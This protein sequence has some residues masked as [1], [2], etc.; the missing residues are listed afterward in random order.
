MQRIFMVSSVFL[1]AV[2]LTACASAV[3]PTRI[4]DYVSAEH[5]ADEAALLNLE[6]RPLQAGLVLVSDTTD[7]G[8]APN[9]P[10][11]AM[12]RLAETLKQDIGRSI[13][14]F[15]KEIIPSDH[16]RPQPNGDWAQFADLGR[17]HGLDYLVVVVLSST[18]Q[19]Y[20]VTLFLG[21]TTHAQPRQLVVVGICAPGFEE[22][23]IA[24]A[25]RRAWL[26]D[27]GSTDGAWNQSVVPRRLPSSA[28]SGTT[29][30]A[31][32]VRR[33]SKYLTCGVVR[34]G[35]EAVGWQTSTYLDWAVG[36]RCIDKEKRLLAFSSWPRSDHSPFRAVPAKARRVLLV[37]EGLGTDSVE[38]TV[39]AHKLQ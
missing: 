7:P 35:G 8:S 14:V 20:P 3:P 34:P 22:Q 36:G 29:D 38:W 9:L 10:D 26:G 5:K 17:Q 11:E 31:S 21:W 33:R 2:V 25:G 15:I 19:E 30:L 16:I 37:F 27:I 6:Q 18:E 23:H 28:G 39:H 1:G 4:G 12:L 32:N 24:D 13:P